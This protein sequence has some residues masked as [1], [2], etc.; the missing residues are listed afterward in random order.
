MLFLILFMIF[1]ASCVG[2]V[3]HKRIQFLKSFSPDVMYYKLYVSKAPKK[4]TNESKS[5]II[6]D[7]V[8]TGKFGDEISTVSVDLTKLLGRGEY[9][10]GVTS[11]GKN[12]EESVIRSLDKVTVVE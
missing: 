4:V 6:N 12:E 3:G 2:F 8:N 11:V 7:G 10:I 5:F 9:Y 1:F